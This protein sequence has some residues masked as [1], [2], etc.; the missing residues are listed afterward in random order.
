VSTSVPDVYEQPLIPMVAAAA[1]SLSAVNVA[2]H[3]Q[4][5]GL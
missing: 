1:A 4:S 3:P 5:P 2:N